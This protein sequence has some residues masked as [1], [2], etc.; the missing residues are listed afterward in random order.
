[1]VL[2]QILVKSEAVCM[3]M[4]KQSH[5]GMHSDQTPDA[6]T[7]FRDWWN[8]RF[9]CAAK[10]Q[11]GAFFAPPLT[12]S[13]GGAPNTVAITI[14]MRAAHARRSCGLTQITR[15]AITGS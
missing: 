11:F 15:A 4:Q 14:T 6:R 2:H 13:I 1:L 3:A 10:Y 12:T 8:A 5:N 9:A 7:R